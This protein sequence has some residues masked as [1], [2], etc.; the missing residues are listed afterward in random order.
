MVK[1]FSVIKGFSKK[2]NLII[3][4]RKNAA[5]L[6]I[7]AFLMPVAVPLPAWAYSLKIASPIGDGLRLAA[8]NTS[9]TNFLGNL[10]NN[11]AAFIPPTGKTEPN[12]EKIYS[13]EVLETKVKGFETQVTD[14]KE[15][16]K[17]EFLSLAAIALDKN[18]NPVNSLESKWKSSNPEIIKIIN[19]SQ[20]LAV[21][22][23]EAKLILSSGKVSKVIFIS[24][25]GNVD[26]K[27]ASIKN[28]ESK[29]ISNSNLVD[30]L[31]VLISEQQADSMVSPENNL[32]NAMGQTEMSSL[33]LASATRTRERAGTANYSFGIPVASLPGR[34]I[35]AS[36]GITYNSHVWSKSEYDETRVFDFNIDKNWLAPGFTL[37]Y[38][39][40]EGYSTY[41]GV[42]VNYLQTDPDGTRRQLVYKQI[43]GNCVTYESTDGTF[44]QTTVCGIYAA[45]Q[46][47][48]L[49][50]DGS[51]ITYGGITTQGKRYPVKIM[52]R[53][54]NYISIAYLDGDSVGKI[55]YI[56]DT[57][58]RYITFHYDN[59]TE[60][61]LVAVTVPGYDNSST[62]RQTIRF[63]YET[64][65]LQ[66]ENRF[67][68]PN[69]QVNAPDTVTVLKYVYF[70]GTQSGF[71][72]DYSP[73]FGTIYKI[74]QLRG[75]QVSTETDLTQTG[76]VNPASD[77]N[78]AAWTHYNYPATAMELPPPLTDVPKYSWRKDDWQGRTTAVPQTTFYTEEQVTITNGLRVGARTTTITNPDGTKNIS[79]SNINQSAWDDGLLKETRLVTIE[80]SQERLWSKTKLYWVQGNNQPQGRDNPRLDKIEVTNDAGQIRATSF[81]Y[82]GYNNQTLAI[83]HDF[84]PE[85][86]LGAEL[87]RIETS[88]ETGQNWINNRLLRLPKEIK[89]K[90]NGVYVAKV[91]YEY[92]G[93]DLLTY[94]SSPITQHD[95]GYDVGTSQEQYCYWVCPSSCNNGGNYLTPCS[96]PLEEVCET[97]TH[98][99]FYRGNVT[100]V[101]AYS[102]A[103]IEGTD[104]NA[105]ISTTKYDILGNPVSAGVN[106]CNLKTW[107]Y[108]AN[109]HY[110]FP[111]SETSGD[112]G[113]LT[114]STTYDLNTSLVKTI[115]DENN[116]PASFT[117][118][119][120]NLRLIRTDSANGSWSTTEYN[121]SSYPFYI[122]ST[123]SLDSTRNVSN[124]SYFD[125][126]GQNFRERSQT[127]TG[128]LSNDVE[129]DVLG[130]PFRSYNPYSVTSLADSRPT[131]TKFT[132]ITQYDG[133]SRILQTKLADDVTFSASYYGLV[134]IVIDQAGKSR[135]AIADALGRTIRVDEPDVN[136]NLGS[137]NSPIQPTVYEYDGNN[138]LSKITQTENG[139]TQERIFKYDSLSRLT[140]EKQVEAT[141][142]LSSDGT[143]GNQ[144]TGVYKYNNKGL[145]SESVDAL[146]VKT[147]FE[148]D[149]L[150]RTKSVTYTGETGYRTPKTI[151]TYDEARN[152]A[153]GNAYFNK[154]RLTSVKTEPD[155]IQ[156]T[157]ETLHTYDYNNVGQIVNHNQSIGNQS[158]NL[159]YAYN[160]AGQL[161]SEKYPSGRVVNAAVDSAGVLSAVSDAQRTYLTGV[162]FNNKGLPS[163]I[164]FGNGTSETFDYNDRLQMM[165]Q[166]LLKG[167]E[168]LQKFSY[169]YGRV[170]LATGNVDTTKNNGQIGRIE[171]FIGTNKQWSQ[172]FGYDELGRLSEAREY[173]AGDNAQLSYKQRFDYDRFGNL[174]RK[175]ASNPTTGQQNPLP[176]V[177]IEAGDID[178]SKNQLA[179][180]TVYD[181]AGQVITDNKFRQMS[182]AYDANGRQ[183]KA[184]KANTPDAYSVYDALGNRVATK[185]YNVWQYMIYNASGALIAEYGVQSEGM[186]GVKY[187][188]QDLQGSVR[189]VINNNGFVVARTDHQAFGEE[190]GL[191]VG[192]RSIEQGYTADKATRQGFGQTENDQATGQQ[193]TW[194][195][196]LETTAGRWTR[197]D[198]SKAQMELT[199]PQS[200]NRYAYV[201]NDPLNFNDP[202]GLS[203]KCIHQAMTRFLAKLAGGR[204]AENADKLAEGAGKADSFRYS[205]TNPFNFFAGIFRK[206]PSAK[207]HFPSTAR[208]ASNMANFN[209]YLDSGNFDKAGFV[210]HSTEDAEGAHDGYDLP[211][212]H[213]IPTLL[214]YIF[215]SK[216]KDTDKNIEGKNFLNAANAVFRL[217][218][219]NQNAN[220]TDEQVKQLQ[221]AIRQEC[222]IKPPEPN[223]GGGGGGTSN[224]GY[225][226]VGGWSQVDWAFFWLRWLSLWAEQQ[227]QQVIYL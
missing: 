71:K 117:Y 39:S 226:P 32:G 168:V 198:P 156:G 107:A 57:L 153:N 87:R 139:V 190:I 127:T 40:I 115:T 112:S 144:W 72:Y 21:N 65:D 191:N 76:T 101:T 56:R 184:S 8:P 174:Y 123:A 125:G 219:N 147:R 124:W 224:G 163:Q 100:K 204:A 48:V 22:E 178:K 113:Q 46:M 149:G 18:N 193:H 109:N 196:K 160:L 3:N 91:V 102:D 104:L 175:A 186:G 88:F 179:T 93:D 218:T 86:V 90:V 4:T 205:A 136:G 217:L 142:T 83:E 110:A 96:C 24:V 66:P 155:A 176:F 187:V 181:D 54:G 119:P 183:I 213:G 61:K 225:L 45:P 227:Q 44:I 177:P 140:H 25:S 134:S 85:N 97:Q 62:P 210:L 58:N 148:Y 111:V 137:V 17:G 162:S 165:N 141:A 151:Y 192:L 41:T 161:V 20:A 98:T 29:V 215:P 11:F 52:D 222:K 89:T 73:Y 33:S 42:G 200:F 68:G 50:P 203:T 53:N 121:D 164:N 51:K 220:L 95:T 114:I 81:G 35:D 78:W 26:L 43:S 212:G 180:G 167:S 130:R 10:S 15:I 185:N 206:G 154:G 126:R 99:T 173:K 138:N 166:S 197:P 63:Y 70:P 5:I 145:L 30:D 74:W 7:F 223:T 132:E 169:E 143:P 172:R 207:W 188:Q 79:V 37:G 31:P 209:G 120:N 182:F 118:N 131:I 128:Y 19:D 152:D 2:S 195:R 157:P 16:K 194:F 201:K 122:K 108:T 77:N 13:K 92:D 103:T 67:E 150:N 211:L 36:I 9:S 159:Q 199:D 34:G 38:G 129:F 80:N 170:D 64:L 14:K 135:R 60:K 27:P 69:V 116:Q 1:F 6:L 216:F 214:S 158:Y 208:L 221:Q 171:S 23:G 28:N 105:V 106:C 133:L 82:D 55:A 75:M 59:T 49:Y 94:G 189:T 12:A 47:T 84:A 202:T 146:V